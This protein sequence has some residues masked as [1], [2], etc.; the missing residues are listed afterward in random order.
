MPRS[1]I[2]RTISLGLLYIIILFSL[3]V[4]VQGHNAPGGGFIAGLIA[5][6]MILI[7]FLSF[8]REH[9]HKVFKPVFHRLL[10]LGVLLAAGSGFFGWLSGTA[11]LTGFHWTIPLPGEAQQALP[12]V[13]FFDLGVYFVVIGTVVSIFMALEEK[14]L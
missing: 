7:Q 2:L 3:F 12:S 4:F 6:A 13:F 1:L 10:G 14:R 8:S 9:V 5:A 11:Y